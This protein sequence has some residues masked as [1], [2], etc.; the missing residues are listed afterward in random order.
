MRTVT[1]L[2]LFNMALS[3]LLSTVFTIPP[4]L[5]IEISPHYWPLGDFMCRATPVINTISVSVSINTMVALALERYIPAHFR[6]SSYSLLMSSVDSSWGVYE[7]W[8]WFW[9]GVECSVFF[10][11]GGGDRERERKGRWWRW[12]SVTR[13]CLG[14]TYILLCTR[15]LNYVQTLFGLA[16]IN[17]VVLLESWLLHFIPPSKIKY[18]HK[19]LCAHSMSRPITLLESN[20]FALSFVCNIVWTVC[21]ITWWS[22]DTW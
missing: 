2:F 9:D 8:W 19:Y 18:L 7:Y 12:M 11:G 14:M 1:N 22:N 15:R 16:I 10:S 3:D 17:I 21:H 6:L 4:M 20:L 13:H 5:A